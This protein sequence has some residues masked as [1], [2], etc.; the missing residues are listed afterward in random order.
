MDSLL[1]LSV[2][3]RSSVI[4]D[5]RDCP[6]LEDAVRFRTILPLARRKPRFID[7]S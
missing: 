6:F 5:R 2:E 3:L 7:D 4:R 1:N